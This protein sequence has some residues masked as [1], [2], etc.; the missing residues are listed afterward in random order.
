MIII[1]SNMEVM[2]DLD[3]WRGGSEFK[4]EWKRSRAQKCRL[5]GIKMI[6]KIEW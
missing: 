3:K 6:R 1:F 2:Q 4:R 5:F